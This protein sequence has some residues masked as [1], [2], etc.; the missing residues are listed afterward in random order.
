MA[1]SCRPP[2]RLRRRCRLRRRSAR[3][4][5]GAGASPPSSAGRRPHQLPPSRIR[6]PR[7]TSS[8]SSIYRT[9]HPHIG[10]QVHEVVAIRRACRRSQAA[11]VVFTADDG[12]AR[13]IDH[14]PGAARKL[15]PASAAEVDDDAA[16]ASARRSFSVKMLVPG[17]VPGCAVVMMMSTSRACASNSAISAAMK[18]GAHL[19]GIAARRCRPL[20]AE[21]PGSRAH[22]AHLVANGGAGVKRAHHGAGVRG[23][24]RLTDPRRRAP[25]TRKTLAGGTCRQRS[26][27]R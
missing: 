25:M 1:D 6:A 27:D 5:Q 10:E 26:S 4:G 13:V 12:D 24:Y 22:A 16:R 15:P 23:R 8:V 2:S 11:W 7:T 21:L 3:H 9:W 18:A 20:R 17:S 14:R 19:A